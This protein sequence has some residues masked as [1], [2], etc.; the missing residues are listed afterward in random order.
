MLPANYDVLPT[1]SDLAGSV[2][3]AHASAINADAVR[4]FYH[5]ALLTYLIPYID[6][7]EWSHTP[8]RGD[9]VVLENAE[10]RYK[11]SCSSITWEWFGEGEP[12]IEYV[13]I[14]DLIYRFVTVWKFDDWRAR[15]EATKLHEKWL[16][17]AGDKVDLDA[18]PQESLMRVLHERGKMAHACGTNACLQ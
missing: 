9:V 4:A 15:V 17:C 14:R 2:I 10:E 7:A 16:S 5:F 11:V 13:T 1:K 6:L 8:L 12:E 18:D 3:Q